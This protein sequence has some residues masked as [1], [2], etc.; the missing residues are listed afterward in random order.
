M[1][2][3]ETTRMK[4]LFAAACLGM[5]VVCPLSARAGSD[6]DERQ[7][8]GKVCLLVVTEEASGKKEDVFKPE[9][10]PG[11]GKA[12]VVRAVA[13]KPCD[14]LVA[15]F[16]RE[17]E[18]LAYGWRPQFVELA[19]EWDEVQIPKSGSKWAWEAEKQAFDVYVVF[20]S[21]TTPKIREI[22]QLVTAMQNSNDDE[23]LE[24]QASRLRALIT[25]ICGDTDPSK[26][27]A[28]AKTTEVSGVM[29]GSSE[30]NWRTF[31]SRV[32]FSDGHPGLLVFRSIG[33]KAVTAT[34][35]PTE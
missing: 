21:T 4:I 13:S 14:I 10:L 12:I 35:T 8:Y 7:P 24:M 33:S 11:L 30:L 19:E 22:K 2:V 5:S 26:H 17:K 27:A 9:S 18:A 28:V 6:D 29:R 25:G 3:T 15:A 1:S 32:N 16:R 31:A 20:L 34:P 23:V